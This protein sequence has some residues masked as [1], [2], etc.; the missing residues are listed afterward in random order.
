MTT[1][2]TTKNT[3]T[4]T[5]TN[6]T[7]NATKFM[8]REE[9]RGEQRY[10]RLVY[11][12]DQT[13]SVKGEEFKVKAGDLG[14][15]FYHQFSLD[16]DC[17]VIYGDSR[18]YIPR[19]VTLGNE[20]A[21][22]NCQFEKIGDGW[23]KVHFEHSVI[24]DTSFIMKEK[25]AKVTGSIIAN[26]TMTDV[27]ASGSKVSRST[28][29]W[30]KIANSR[31][32]KTTGNKH[33][34]EDSKV[35]NCCLEDTVVLKSFVSKTNAKLSDIRNSRVKNSVIDWVHLGWCTV[36]N[37]RELYRITIENSIVKADFPVYGV[38]DGAYFHDALIEAPYDAAQVGEHFY[39]RRC[40]RELSYVSGLHGHYKHE[41]TPC[42]PGQQ[43]VA[44]RLGAERLAAN[45]GELSMLVPLN[46]MAVTLYRV[47]LANYLIDLVESS[48]ED[49][50]SQK[51]T[52]AVADGH[53]ILDPMSAKL[54]EVPEHNLHNIYVL[55]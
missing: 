23:G 34:I 39:Y 44:K 1:T 54:L 49:A 10:W 40:A 9:M 18:T 43:P 41:E 14:P 8:F 30:M 42:N 26:C 32:D 28:L 29:T 12:E 52:K 13:I 53:N 19:G 17:Q 22:I 11:T 31:V 35:T 20:V 55:P 51:V 50:R 33:C 21:I 3:N 46:C 36:E 38:K 27:D 24:K 6:T 15:L 4:N 48:P 47:A 45:I 16:R 7:I 37:V 5:N 2:T 25:S